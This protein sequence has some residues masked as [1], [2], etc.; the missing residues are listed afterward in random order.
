MMEVR[1]R[2]AQGHWH[3]H[4]IYTIAEA[5]DARIPYTYWKD[6]QSGDEGRYFCSDDGYVGECLSVKQYPRHKTDKA[7][8]EPLDTF[9]RLSVGRGVANQWGRLRFELPG[10]VGEKKQLKKKVMIAKLVSEALLTGKPVDWE[11][12]GNIWRPNS[13]EWKHVNAK[14]LVGSERMQNMIKDEVAKA[15]A[16]SPWSVTR[17]LARYNNLYNANRKRDP[18]FA[19]SILDRV[20][21]FLDMEPDKQNMSIRTSFNMGGVSPAGYLPADAD[22]MDQLNAAAPVQGQLTP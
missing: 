3:L 20:A 2:D 9:V 21:T 7:H 8:P 12:V 14:R 22:E 17:V 4:T 18:E 19:K 15:L 5:N 6:A 16:K 13:G 10:T 11:V 1:R